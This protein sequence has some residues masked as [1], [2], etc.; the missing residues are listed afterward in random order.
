MPK[1]V[2]SAIRVAAHTSMQLVEI[3]PER[4]VHRGLAVHRTVQG[5][6][7]KGLVGHP[8]GGWTIT[9]IATGMAVANSIY[10]EADARR[11][12]RLLAEDF[13]WTEA[14]PQRLP[15]ASRIRAEVI[16]R[17]DTV[18]IREMRENVARYLGLLDSR[19]GAGAE[20]PERVMSLDQ[21]EIRVLHAVIRLRTTAAGIASGMP[22]DV[23]SG[24]GIR[25]GREIF[26]ILQDLQKRG[27]L[28]KLDGRAVTWQM[29]ARA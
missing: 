7:E 5:A 26:R 2:V 10:A 13:D 1:G 14:Q 16:S 6:E 18:K 3:D 22:E 8:K 19:A 23:K 28:D 25:P 24:L 4:D 20:L 11:A 12:M 9:H 27:Y 21:M 17:I 29:K 15:E